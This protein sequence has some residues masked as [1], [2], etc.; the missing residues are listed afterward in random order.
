[1]LGALPHRPA[2]WL[3]TFVLA[4]LF[5]FVDAF[6]YARFKSTIR[7]YLWTIVAEWAF[8]I[9][10]VLIIL[11]SGL[12]LQNFGQSF[13]TY[14]R[15][16][17]ICA[18]LFVFVA[19]LVLSSKMRTRK[20]T[21]SPER[22]AKIAKAVEEA[23]KLLPKN[24]KERI[25]FVAVAFTAGFCEEF[26]YRGWLLN[27]TGYALKSVLLGLL[28]SSIFFGFAH[29]Y[30][31]GGGIIKTGVVGLVFGLIY[32]ASGS[33]LPG[34]ILHALFDLNNGLAVAKIVSRV[35]ASP[36]V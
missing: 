30:Q 12:S 35:E 34:Q 36:S 16:L 7:L 24:G 11:R 21:A 31:G 32:V 23:R 27:L 22:A 1:M 15:T 10:A 3:F 26:L 2:I 20:S 13:G 14:P 6:V 29:L 17:I 8:I 28:I 19:A 18:I 9:V 5:P 25:L 4:V 33:L